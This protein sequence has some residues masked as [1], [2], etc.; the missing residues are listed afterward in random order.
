M[1]K[2]VFILLF[3]L[4]NLSLFS[5]STN[6]TILTINGQGIS[7]EE[8][9]KVYNKNNSITEQSNKKSVD[10]YID[11]FINYKLKVFEAKNKGYDTVKAFIDEFEGYRKQL[12][13]P[14]LQNQ[15]LKDKLIEEAYERYKYE[16]KASHILIN[17][18]SNASPEDTLK[19]YEKISAIKSRIQAGE[20]FIEVARA[21]SDD[22][23]VKQN[24]GD[25]G[26][27]TVFRMVYPFETAAYSTKVGK[28][29]KIIRTEFGYH[30]LQVN[31]KRKSRGLV[32]AAHIMVRI[33]DAEAGP[34]KTAAKEKI[35]EAYHALMDG[36]EWT[37]AVEKYSENPRTKANKGEVGWLQVGQAPEAFLDPV[38]KLEA[39]QF[40]KP[41]ETSG[42]YHIGYVIEK[43]SIGK[44][45]EAKE[46]LAKKIDNDER[47]R[48]VLKE[49][50]LTELKN[51]YTSELYPE[52]VKALLS[53][54]DNSIFSKNWDKNKTSKY[55]KPVLTVGKKEYT[56]HNFA[57]FLNKSKRAANNEQPL[58]EI[59][60]EKL[61]EYE[62]ECLN[63][64]AMQ[65]LPEENPDYRYLLQEYHDGIL[66]F[67]LTNDVV[68]QKAQEDSAGLAD[69]YKD[70]K[71][72]YWNK[73]IQVTVFEYTDNS[74]TVTL[75][76]TLKKLSKK[77]N[78]LA[79]VNKE[80]CPNDTVGCIII[81]EKTFV[82][83][84][85]A[86]ADKLKWSVGSHVVMS[87]ADKNHLY[88]VT[89]ILP[90]QPKE[91]IEA[92]G[93]YIADYQNYLEKKWIEDLRKKYTVEINT[94]VLKKVKEDLD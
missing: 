50:I 72:Y 84:Q 94:E 65:K 31:D 37:E 89:K 21:T 70:S 1:K 67:N 82:K 81:S 64:Y 74:L 35:E 36:M 28:I 7:S 41:V 76:K 38:F 42:G 20:S 11:L 71:K 40:S 54:I 30:I 45:E 19:A 23:S 14:H 60:M 78:G 62:D 59:M 57:I 63:E 44:F 88:Y 66:L 49:Q 26:Y 68:W 10:E 56:Q 27:F 12:A 13:K 52:N 75:P 51:K 79:D 15:K 53:S 46:K 43:K 6:E 2:V 77:E 33:P 32:K 55:Q 69:F 58:E 9:L 80:L 47:R 8:F 61:E 86:I 24:N 91:L 17:C 4:I 93:L 48:T 90:K 16:I 73:R 29:S 22:P 92:R 18:K 87:E 83:D 85:D 3:T 25:L 34:E 5:Q 39:E